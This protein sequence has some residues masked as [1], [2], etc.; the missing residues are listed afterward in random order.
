VNERE[1]NLPARAA[2]LAAGLLALSL[3]APGLLAASGRREPELRAADLTRQ[4]IWVDLPDTSRGPAQLVV[5]FGAGRLDIVPGTRRALV[6]GEALYNNELF[7]PTVRA[8]GGRTILSAGDGR[9][10][11]RE[12]IDSW[13]KIKDHLN[14]W[15]LELAPV[16]TELEL[17]LG[18]SSASLDLGG[19]PLRRLKL[20]QGA[21][22]LTLDFVR[23]NPVEMAVLTYNGGASRGTLRGLA[24]ANTSRVEVYGGGGAFNL[25]FSGRLRRDLSVKVEA[26]A[27]EVA[28]SFPLEADVEVTTHTGLAVVDFRG[29]WNRPSE[30]LYRHPGQRADRG[31]RITVDAS[32]LAGK[33]LLLAGE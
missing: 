7:T 5:R 16:P 28:L 31:P 14:R 21:A 25:D 3:A 2:R 9:L 13:S 8:E 23:P 29:T 1:S 27:G 18:A 10:E 15:E 30:H 17:E 20:S 11:L 19:L 6:S 24:N 22:D 26:G 32:V 33:L 4:P 12:F